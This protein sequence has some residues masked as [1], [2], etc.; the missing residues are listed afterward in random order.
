VEYRLGGPESSHAI[1]QLGRRGSATHRGL[2]PT[3]IDG[4]SV[5]G[6][7]GRCSSAHPGAI[8]GGS[9]PRRI[10]GPHTSHVFVEEAHHVL[11]NLPE[12]RVNRL[13]ADL[14]EHVPHVLDQDKLRLITRGF[15]VSIEFNRLRLKHVCVVDTLDNQ[16]RRRV[17]DNEM[18]GA[19]KNQS[20]AV[21]R[22]QDGATLR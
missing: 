5:I 17:R 21:A 19:S 14:R 13:R 6:A 11:R 4:A 7:R 8:Q 2:G 20:P 12:T 9:T 3:D 18:R 1:S 10:A 15:E 22:Q 16:N